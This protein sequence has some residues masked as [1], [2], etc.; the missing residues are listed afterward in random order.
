MKLPKPIQRGS[1]H[2]VINQ[3]G[4]HLNLNLNSS[5]MAQQGSEESGGYKLLHCTSNLGASKQHRGHP[6]LKHCFIKIINSEGKMLNTVAFGK[7]GLTAEPYAHLPSTECTVQISG[8]S[9]RELDH[10]LSHVQQLA[11]VPYQWKT[12]NCC[13]ILNKALTETIGIPPVDQSQQAIH[14]LRAYADRS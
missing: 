2:G 7:A 12:H 3:P 1:M 9:A 5:V 10:Y 8:L 11:E 14:S 4:R 13:S 6:L